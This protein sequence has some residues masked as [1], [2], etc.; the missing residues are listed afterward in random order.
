MR[1]SR[2]IQEFLQD[3]KAAGKAKGT[4]EGY[5][6]DLTRVLRHVGH[7]TVLQLTPEIL[8]ALFRDLSQADLKLST[9]HRKASCVR[10]FIRWGERQRLFADPHGLE[11]AIPHIRR[12]ELLPRP[13]SQDETTRLW[14]LELSSEERVLR[15]LL[16]YTGLRVSAICA[17]LVGNV[18][19]HPPVIATIT[20]GGRTVLKPMHPKLA[21]MVFRALPMNHAEVGIFWAL[22]APA[23]KVGSTPRSCI[24]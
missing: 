7:D 18:S 17:I 11:L 6:S 10:E 23:Q 13:F 8:T 3:K 1:I 12:Q 20:K 9:L 14:A 16:F 4:L 24:S 15:A 22:A 19:E 5:Q 2:A 21:E